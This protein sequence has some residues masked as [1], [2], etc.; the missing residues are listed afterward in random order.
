MSAPR[1]LHFPKSILRSRCR[2][3]FQENAYHSFSVSARTS[4]KCLCLTRRLIQ[5]PELGKSCKDQHTRELFV[6]GFL[7]TSVSASWEGWL[8]P[9]G[10]VFAP[11]LK[12]LMETV[13]AV[14]PEVGC[15]AEVGWGMVKMS[16]VLNSIPQKKIFTKR[17]GGGRRGAE[18]V[19]LGVLCF[20]RPSV[21]SPALKW[22]QFWITSA[23]LW[24][25]GLHVSESASEQM[26]FIRLR[27]AGF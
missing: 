22:V 6:L 23:F 2:G 25:W 7:T 13:G 5:G 26:D 3:G 18:A 21:H 14:L 11:S 8:L 17:G 15:V 20:R 12:F 9:R 1:R 27:R 24:P 16:L 4:F 19:D 10:D